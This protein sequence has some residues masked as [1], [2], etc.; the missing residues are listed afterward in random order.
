MLKSLIRQFKKGRDIDIYEDDIFIVSFPK[1]GNTWVRFLLSNIQNIKLTINFKNIDEYIPD[2][3]KVNNFNLKKIQRPRILK[4]HEYFHPK[5]KKVIYIVRDPRSLIVSYFFY[6]KKMKTIPEDTIFSDYLKIF[7]ENKNR[8]F[9]NWED[10]INSWVGTRSNKEEQFLLIKYED[11]LENTEKELLKITNFI[12]MNI[13]EEEL[14]KSIY[15]NSFKKMKEKE[16]V[17][18]NEIPFVR[19]A[20]PEEWK[21]YFSKEDLDLLNKHLKK[22]MQSLGYF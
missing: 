16:E 10:H 15:E 1:S 8:I 14:K 18:E 5:Y 11:L 3:Y 22:T 20:D 6:E 2:I 19:K 9:S 13:S 4:S 7:L 17:K 12:N 21:S